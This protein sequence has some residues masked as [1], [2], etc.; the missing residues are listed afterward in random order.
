MVAMD[1]ARDVGI[2]GGALILGG[3]IS[4]ALAL[5][6][7]S[8]SA[9]G[10]DGDIELLIQVPRVE[11]GASL[12]LPP[13]DARGRAIPRGQI[14]VAAIP[15]CKSCTVSTLDVTGLGRTGYRASVLIVPDG[16]PLPKCADQRHPSLFVVYASKCKSIPQAMVGLP[17]QAVVLSDAG[18]VTEVGERANLQEFIERWGK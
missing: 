5:G 10:G 4:V 2:V 7:P 17:P 9:M 6:L 11:I 14:L 12:E 8:L 15:P 16:D 3:G 13:K 1:L 18:V